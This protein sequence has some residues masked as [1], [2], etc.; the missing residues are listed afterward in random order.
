MNI[1]LG[2]Q[3]SHCLFN[4]FGPAGSLVIHFVDLIVGNWI[5]LPHTPGA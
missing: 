3:T 2:N 1:I 4:L 5:T